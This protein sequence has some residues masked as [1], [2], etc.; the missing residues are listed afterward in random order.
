M[1]GRQL[2]GAGEVRAPEDLGDVGVAAQLVALLLAGGQVAADEA[3][4]G[5]VQRHADGNAALVAEPA[6][7]APADAVD[8]EVADVLHQLPLHPHRQEQPHHLLAPDQ[9]VAYAAAAAAARLALRRRRASAT[10]VACCFRVVVA[11]AGGCLAVAGGRFG[12]CIGAVHG[13]AYLRCPA[14][15]GRRLGGAVAGLDERAVDAV[16]V[17]EHLERRRLEEERGVAAAVV[18][19][20]VCGRLRRRR[21]VVVVGLLLGL[22]QRLV[23]EP[24]P[25]GRRLVVLHDQHVSGGQGNYLLKPIL[26]ASDYF[27]TMQKVRTYQIYRQDIQTQIYYEMRMWPYPKT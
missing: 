6:H 14:A 2:A 12:L 5:A 26:V 25:P 20:G 16:A 18:A 27:R 23:D 10:A 13:R 1:A 7:D 8:A 3:E 11:P 17:A 9:A 19:P 22:V 21:V 24:Q 15:H 4:A